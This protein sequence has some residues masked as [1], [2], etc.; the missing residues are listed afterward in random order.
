MVWTDEKEAELKAAGCWVDCAYETFH[1][2]EEGNPQ[3]PGHTFVL[4]LY[5]DL[6]QL[7][8]WKK[9]SREWIGY[10]L[11]DGKPWKDESTPESNVM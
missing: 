2:L 4:G 11:K 5:L 7:V 9:I 8:G 10:G 3:L 6:A 1:T